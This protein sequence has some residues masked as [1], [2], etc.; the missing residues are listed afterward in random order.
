M[1]FM[2]SFCRKAFRFKK[3]KARFKS[4]KVL[5]YKTIKFAK[6][7]FLIIFRFGIIKALFGKER[8]FAAGGN[9]GRS[10]QHFGQGKVELKSK[11]SA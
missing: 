2:I 8:I 11:H 1:N 10:V 9:D 7:D 5:N 4:I 3:G 6:R